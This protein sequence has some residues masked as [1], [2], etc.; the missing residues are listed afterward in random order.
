[1]AA[2]SVGGSAGCLSAIA[3]GE[4]VYM[5]QCHL[6][7]VKDNIFGIPFIFIVSNKVLFT[8]TGHRVIGEK[9]VTAEG[10]RELETSFK[11]CKPGE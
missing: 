7:V 8:A 2:T 4:G 5:M 9:L 10:R 3:E 1:M 6:G 11:V